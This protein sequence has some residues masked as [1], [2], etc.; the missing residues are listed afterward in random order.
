MEQIRGL[1]FSRSINYRTDDLP[2]LWNVVREATDGLGIPVLA[3]FDCGHSDPMLTVPLGVEVQLDS[4]TE[5]FV[6]S[7]APTAG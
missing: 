7:L 6:T 5:T 2:V 4:V 1:V 3:N